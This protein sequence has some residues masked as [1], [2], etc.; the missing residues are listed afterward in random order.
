M[1]EFLRATALWQH[2]GVH[3]VR[4]EAMVKGFNIPLSLEFDEGDTPETQYVL[5]L[6]G[7]LPVATCRLHRVDGQTAKIER[8]CVLESYRD[9]KIGRDMILFAESWLGELGV[10]KIVITSRDTAVGFYETLGYRADWN[11]T[12]DTGVFKIVYTEK[13]IRS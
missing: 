6:D 8:V 2:A 3:Y 12:D 5:A 4:T 9:Q 10:S 1:I 7:V 11:Q 13:I